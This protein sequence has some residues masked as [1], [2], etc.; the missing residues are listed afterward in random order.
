M[1]FIQT[2]VFDPMLEGQA[3]ALKGSTKGKYGHYSVD[4]NYIIA[5]VNGKRM[6]VIGAYGQYGIL[7]SDIES[8]AVKMDILGVEKPET[9]KQQQQEQPQQKKKSGIT[10]R[11]RT[12]AERKEDNEYL[13]Y[14]LY[15]HG[16]PMRL[17]D[18][19]K[20]MIQNGRKHWD[21]HNGC[22][23]IK[24]AIKDGRKIDRVGYG[25]YSYIGGQ[26]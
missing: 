11:M 25:M 26:N 22:G 23:F 12:D 4:G 20:L 14:L 15:E 7:V 8:N 2:K 18:I 19:I 21:G 5:K 16:K 13:E 3:V 10:R 9:Q 6:D 24:T 17:E 1:V